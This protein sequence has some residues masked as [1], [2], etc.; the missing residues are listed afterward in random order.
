MI[1]NS[2]KRQK[3][4]VFFSCNFMFLESRV[5]I[6]FQEIY[7]YCKSVS[8]LSVAQMRKI[9]FPIQ[10]LQQAAYKKI[11]QKLIWSIT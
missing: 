5:H 1:K 9:K 6:S 7:N 2:D 8:L 11:F 3:T 4:F 10:D